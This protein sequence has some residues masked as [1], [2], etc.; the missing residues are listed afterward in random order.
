MAVTIPSSPHR[1]DPSQLS[2][3]ALI[4]GDDDGA[5]WEEVQENLNHYAAESAPPLVE[6]WVNDTVATTG[7]SYITLY[8]TTV[9]IP[10]D[11]E[12]VTLVTW[13]S[14]SAADNL[15]IEIGDGTNT[16]ETA[17]GTTPAQQTAT[18]TLAAT[19]DVTLTVKA[20][21]ISGNATVLGIFAELTPIAAISLPPS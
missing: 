2:M 13:G 3:G 10:R 1:P 19:G 6:V 14:G 17:H 16:A 11:Y 15:R 12:E 8:E 20:R 5:T 7:A 18:L 4:D 21:A 9:H